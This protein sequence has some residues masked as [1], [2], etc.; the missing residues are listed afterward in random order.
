[1]NTNTYQQNLSEW[2]TKLRNKA[3]GEFIQELVPVLKQ[4]GYDLEDFLSEM[5]NH[6]EGTRSDWQQASNCVRQAQ[7]EIEKV[8][9]DVINKDDR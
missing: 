8:R 1:M 3:L 9:S 5:A 7:E 6:I 4:N 2:L